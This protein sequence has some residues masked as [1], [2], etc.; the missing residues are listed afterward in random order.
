MT[1]AFEWLKST[2]TALESV[3]TYGEYENQEN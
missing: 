2:K 3:D 1:D